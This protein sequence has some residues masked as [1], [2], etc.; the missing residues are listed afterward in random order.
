MDR[1]LRSFFVFVAALLIFPAL[2]QAQPGPARPA[3]TPAP[4]TTSAAVPVTRIAVI[5]SQDFQDP[6]TGI[7][8]FNVLLTKLNAEFQKIQNDLNATA[9]KLRTLQAEIANLQN[10]PNTSPALIQ[11]KIDQLDQQK[12]DYNRRG[13]DAQAGY[14]KRRVELFEPL[15]N[16]ITKALDTY[17]K[18]RGLTMIL[19]GSTMPLVYA[20]EGLDITKVFIADY[21][22]KNPVPTPTP[23]PATTKPK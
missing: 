9:Q 23:T 18:A 7:A 12:R 8:R 19:D 13:E 11:T 14:Q 20:A 3:A 4:Q 21:N 16:D 15:Q 22:S 5:Y 17:A 1:K 6:K 10:A 2:A